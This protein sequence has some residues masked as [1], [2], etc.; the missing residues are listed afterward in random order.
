MIRVADFDKD[1]K[2]SY[3]DF[4]Q[5]MMTQPQSQPQPGQIESIT[6]SNE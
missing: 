6:K 1:G 3:K 4:Y 2:V 5:M